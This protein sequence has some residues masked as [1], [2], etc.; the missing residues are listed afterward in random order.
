MSSRKKKKTPRGY[1]NI[2]TPHAGSMVINVQRESG[3]ANRTIVLSP[4]RVRL[5]RFALSRVGLVLIAVFAI[6]WILL[7]I[8]ATR[9][10]VLNKRLAD[11]QR[12][13][14]RLDTLQLKLA[15]L[16]SRYEQVQKMLGAAPP[17]PTI[18]ATWPLPST[19]FVTRGSAA[20]SDYSGAHPG[21][22]I[23]TPVGTDVRAAGGGSVV[24]VS[25]NPEYGIFVRLANAD[26]YETLYGHLSQALVKTG[27]QVAEGAVIAKS[28]NT[29]RSTA[30][31]LHFEVRLRAQPVD[32]M[33]LIKKEP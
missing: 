10:P 28:G 3:L 23:A 7:A 16:Q 31:H 13:A 26:G 15:V 11:M 14:R 25:E 30:P 17:S 24:E 2:Y 1:G 9:L 33:Q 6:S 20:A 18:P 8:Q 32:P 22:D 12:D 27:D 4:R 21:I 29:G 19:G 5:L